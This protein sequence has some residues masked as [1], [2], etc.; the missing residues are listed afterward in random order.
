MSRLVRSLTYWKTLRVAMA[1]VDVTIEVTSSP[2]P[3]PYPPP[4]LGTPSHVP[5]S[6]RTTAVRRARRPPGTRA[7]HVGPA[8]RAHASRAQT[9]ARERLCVCMCPRERACATAAAAACGR[10]C[11]GVLGRR[12]G[13]GC[14]CVL[15]A[16]PPLA[17]LAS[18]SACRRL[19]RGAARVPR[20][21]PSHVPSQSL[22][23]PVTPRR[24]SRPE[25]RLESH[26]PSPPRRP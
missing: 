17:A 24:Q 10:L 12:R 6:A 2:V 19:A 3:R 14:V 1:E 9:R 4:C 5:S 16:A 8:S 25:A 7:R 20:P 23:V 13:R 11:A 26:A 21:A 15:E 18:P 22:P